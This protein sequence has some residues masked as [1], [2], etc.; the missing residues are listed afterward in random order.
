MSL[1]VLSFTDSDTCGTLGVTATPFIT[2]GMETKPGQHP[3][4]AALYHNK[5][6]Q[7][8]YICGANLVS[9][10]FVVTVAHCA[11]R[12]AT[13]APLKPTLLVVILGKYYLDRL[14]TAGIQERNVS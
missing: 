4:H 6:I 9:R 13:G 5:N 11:T 8:T 12:Q 1:I 3:W 14:A 10:N 2:H 7:L